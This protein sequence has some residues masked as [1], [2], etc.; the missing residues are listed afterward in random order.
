MAFLKLSLCLLAVVLFNVDFIEAKPTVTCY[1][2]AWATTRGKFHIEDID[3]K[4]CTHV[5]YAF[6]G[7]NENTSEIISINSTLDFDEGG[8]LKKLAQLKLLNKDLKVLVSIG[9]YLQGSVRFSDMARDSTRKNTFI[10]SIL[11]FIKQWELDGIDICW[12]FPGQRGGR[13]EDRKNFVSLLKDIK[14]TFK[15]DGWLLTVHIIAHREKI[16]AGYDVKSISQIV[17]FINFPALEYH[18]P[19]DRT[20]GIMAPLD[21]KVGEG[22]TKM[23]DYVLQRGAIPSKILLGVPTYG[24]AYI[25]EE[26]IRIEDKYIGLTSDIPFS[27][28][29]TNEPGIIAYNE[30]C[31]NLKNDKNWKEGFDNDSFTPIA[32]SNRI[33]VSFDNKKSLIEKAK[34][35]ISRKLG[36]IMLW[37]VDMDDF[38]GLCHNKT[39]PMLSAVTDFL[40]GEEQKALNPGIQYNT[41]G[42]IVTNSSELEENERLHLTLTNSTLSES[43]KGGNQLNNVQTVNIITMLI[44]YTLYIFISQ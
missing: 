33:F 35:V 38:Q 21:P 22:V 40:I 17:D 30:I 20:T 29:W 32:Y 27:S 15:A 41:T 39:Y 5:I 10:N 28:P 23:V 34:L 8:Q 3:T 6:M 11:K 25:T 12:Q 37:S 26:P 14:A 9:G 2:A 43:S 13:A 24:H 4:H 1:V 44:S 19:W 31:S 42:P 7:V 16:R 36:G 18:G